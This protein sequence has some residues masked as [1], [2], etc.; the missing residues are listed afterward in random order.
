MRSSGAGFG[1]GVWGASGLGFRMRVFETH[2]GFGLG[3]RSGAQQ[4]CRPYSA[5]DPKP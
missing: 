2:V 1:F 5:L 3:V 4:K